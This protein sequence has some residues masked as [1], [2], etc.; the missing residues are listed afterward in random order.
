MTRANSL[1][2]L[3]DVRNRSRKGSEICISEMI[4]PEI[5]SKNLHLKLSWMLQFGSRSKTLQQNLTI[6]PTW[7]LKKDFPNDALVKIP[8]R[9][10]NIVFASY[11]LLEVPNWGKLKGTLCRCTLQDMNIGIFI[12]TLGWTLASRLPET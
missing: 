5:F 10:L 2:E 12:W 8:V 3:T 6:V 1:L 11:I 4:K 7:D 9:D